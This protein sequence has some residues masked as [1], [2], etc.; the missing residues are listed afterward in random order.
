MAQISATWPRIVL[1]VRHEDVMTPQQTSLVGRCLTGRDRRRGGRSRTL[2]GD[3]DAAGRYRTA[4]V[5]QVLRW[6]SAWIAS[7]HPSRRPGFVF[8]ALGVLLFAKP[9]RWGPV[10]AWASSGRSSCHHRAAEAPLRRQGRESRRRLWL[11]FLRWAFPDA[12]ATTI[13]SIRRRGRCSSSPSA[14]RCSSAGQ[15]RR[16]ARSE[17]M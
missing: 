17:M 8:I 10:W 13:L 16:V 4:I 7:R 2:L 14:S 1:S 3:A 15:A 5:Q 12:Y 9:A 6:R 11:T